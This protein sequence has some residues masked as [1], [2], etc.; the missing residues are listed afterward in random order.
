MLNLAQALAAAEQQHCLIF[1][2]RVLGN[3]KL[4]VLMFVCLFSSYISFISQTGNLEGHMQPKQILNYIFAYG[5]KR[6]PK[7]T[8]LAGRNNFLGYGL[9]CISLKPTKLL[10]SRLR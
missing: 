7:T 8:S 4:G 6:W 1:A 3:K 10:Q 9:S 5:A 2:E